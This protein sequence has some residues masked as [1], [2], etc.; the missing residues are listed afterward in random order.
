LRGGA[1]ESG[2]AGPFEEAKL[3][4]EAER[5]AAGSSHRFFFAE[6]LAELAEELLKFHL[7]LDAEHTGRARCRR[8]QALRGLAESLGIMTRFRYQDGH[9]MM[10]GRTDE[11]TDTAYHD[12]L[13][14]ADHN[15]STG[16]L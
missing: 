5:V 7:G 15:R 1:I 13:V 4:D 6:D 14:K 2:F 12:F 8:H 11:E 16:A 10:I 3:D 9:W